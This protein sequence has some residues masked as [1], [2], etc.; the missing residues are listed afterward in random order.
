MTFSWALS[1]SLR[2][3]RLVWTLDE[4]AGVHVGQPAV[5]SSLLGITVEFQTSNVS[6]TRLW[7]A[8]KKGPTR[9]FGKIVCFAG[10]HLHGRRYSV[11][12][13]QGAS[14]T[15]QGSMFKEFRVCTI[16]RWFGHLKE[17]LFLKF[18]II[19]IRVI[20]LIFFFYRSHYITVPWY[21]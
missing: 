13:W 21:R 12:A 8:I 11:A 19:Y 18:S 14:N 16:I 2:V 1:C 20:C 6:S 9:P 10:D 4:L 5:G 17:R 15:Q 3:L 7:R